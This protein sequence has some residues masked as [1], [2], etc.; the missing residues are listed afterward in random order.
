MKTVG[1]THV[2]ISKKYERKTLKLHQKNSDVF[3]VVFFFIITDFIEIDSK[4]IL[5][6]FEDFYISSNVREANLLLVEEQMITNLGLFLAN[7]FWP[8]IIFYNS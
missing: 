7:T 8:K 2:F 5:S 4:L 6:F 3:Y 1:N